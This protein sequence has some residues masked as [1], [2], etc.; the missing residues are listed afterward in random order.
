MSGNQEPCDQ[1]KVLFTSATDYAR[2]S[3]PVIPLY[4][5]ANGKCSCGK[6]SCAS[7]AKH[8]RTRQGLKDASVEQSKIDIWWHRWLQANIGIRTGKVSGIVVLDIDPRQ[9]GNESLDQLI[10]KHGELPTTVEAET[11]GG[12]RHLVFR[13]PGGE[14]RNRTNIRPG[15][16]V[17]GDNGYIVAPPSM[18]ISG[19]CYAWKLGH[20]PDD[21][22]LPPLPSWLVDLITSGSASDERCGDILPMKP[23]GQNGFL[24]EAASRYIAKSSGAAEGQ[25]NNAAFNLAGHMASFQTEEGLQLEEGQIVEL[26]RM[27]NQQNQPPLL[28]DELVNTIHSAMRNGT[29]REPHIVKTKTGVVPSFI[30][31]STPDINALPV[32]ILPGGSQRVIDSAE[33]MGELLAA[34]ECHFLRGGAVVMLVKDSGGARR[35][36][37]LKPASMPSAFEQV[38]RLVKV[39]IK[40]GEPEYVDT[41]C[42]EQTAKILRNRSRVVY[43]ESRLGAG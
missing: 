6:V 42:N 1:N 30:P 22:D 38:A 18:H 21:L 25:R 43:Q 33:Q 13:H 9:G 39:A 3:W 37:P 24:F 19:Q 20:A 36:Q 35:L 5:V 23:L 41:T 11:G 14:F 12:G 34:T 10:A 32:A 4:S 29:P 28:D 7:P 27:W 31:T 26:L 2:R 8:P 16:D 15:I 17:R 40:D